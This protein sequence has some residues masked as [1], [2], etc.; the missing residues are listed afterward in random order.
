MTP[1]HEVFTQ[2]IKEHENTRVKLVVY[3]ILTQALRD[4]SAWTATPL[5]R[6]TLNTP[7]ISR[8]LTQ[9]WPARILTW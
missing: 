2:A 8:P 7:E 9:A 1:H 4:V 3:S 6:S 5:Q